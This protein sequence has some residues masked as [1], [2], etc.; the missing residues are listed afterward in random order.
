[1]EDRLSM[2]IMKKPS[3]RVID[4]IV[5][6]LRKERGAIVEQMRMA[7]NVTPE[8]LRAAV[9]AMKITEVRPEDLHAMRIIN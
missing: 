4:S 3:R 6:E 7:G 9:L 2:T 1:M 8:C 5:L